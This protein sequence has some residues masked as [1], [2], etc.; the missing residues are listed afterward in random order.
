MTD[1]I[2]RYNS[3]R[4]FGDCITNKSLFI[5]LEK[6]IKTFLIPY[7]RSKKIAKFSLFLPWQQKNAQ[8]LLHLSVKTLM[9]T[10]YYFCADLQVQV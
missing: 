10:D 6:N 3:H 9:P 4:S 7:F 5:V 1:S 2:D 8:L